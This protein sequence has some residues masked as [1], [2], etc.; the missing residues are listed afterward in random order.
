MALPWV[1]D[2]EASGFGRGSYPIEVGY[3]GPASE[4]GCTLIRPEPDWT[5][6][7]PSAAKVHGIERTVLL[8]H[9]RPVGIVARMLNAALAGQQVYCDAWAHDYVWLAR[10]FDAAD[11][12]PTFRLRDLR[13]LLEPHELDRFDAVREH[14]RRETALQRHRASGDARVLQ[15]SVAALRSQA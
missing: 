15:M 2:V 7:D 13:E 10:L 5:G 11:V 4:V 6:W 8:Q 3:V 9:G 14:V 12:V 1:L